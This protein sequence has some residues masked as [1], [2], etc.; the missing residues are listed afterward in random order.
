MLVLRNPLD[1]EPTTTSGVRSAGLFGDEAA[2]VTP[3][4][5]AVSRPKPPEPVVVTAAPS[6]RYTVEAIRAAKRTEEE[7]V[8]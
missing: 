1:Q 6:P 5:R 3:V 4:V 7:V 2:P 8:Q